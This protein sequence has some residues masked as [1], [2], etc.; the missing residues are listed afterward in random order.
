MGAESGQSGQFAIC[1]EHLSE[2]VDVFADF[3][4]LVSTLVYLV[5]ECQ[6]FGTAQGGVDSAVVTLEEHDRSL[7]YLCII[8]QSKGDLLK[9]V[10]VFHLSHR[11]CPACTI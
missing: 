3:V 8:K 9:V 5:T 6:D 1:P 2:E 4:D 7:D 11:K 10:P